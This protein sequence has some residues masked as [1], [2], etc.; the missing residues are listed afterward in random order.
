[1][2]AAFAI[3]CALVILWALEIRFRE[4]RKS[5]DELNKTAEDLKDRL[6]K[7]EGDMVNLYL[8]KG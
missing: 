6:E 1:M 4:Y 8:K 3:I 7:I 5:I 2:D